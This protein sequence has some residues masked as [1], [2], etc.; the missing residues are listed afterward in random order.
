VIF[1]Q[2]NLQA[3]YLTQTISKPVLFKACPSFPF[4]PSFHRDLRFWFGFKAQ[5]S[6]NFGEQCSVSLSLSHLMFSA[7]TSLR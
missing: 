1:T 7:S 5:T 2:K 3:I 4:V 6:K